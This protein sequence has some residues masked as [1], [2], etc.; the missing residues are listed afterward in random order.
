M[1]PPEAFM[2]DS[3]TA[4]IERDDARRHPFGIELNLE[5]TEIAA[6]ALDSGDA[7]HG[8][9]S[10]VHVVFREIAQRHQICGPGS[11]SRVNSKISFRR[12]V[13][14]EMSGGSVPCGS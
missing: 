13:R 3:S 14:L 6:E 5:L 10:I 9:Q 2:F 8:Q 1:I 4:C 7:R 11:A 12:P